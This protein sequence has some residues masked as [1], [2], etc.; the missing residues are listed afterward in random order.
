M[1]EIV[2]LFGAGINR[3]MRWEKYGCSPPLAKDFFQQL[4]K[5]ELFNREFFLNDNSELFEYIKKFWKISPDD[6]KKY[7]FDI[8]E[9]FTL[10]QLQKSAEEKYHN[11]E[12]KKLIKIQNQFTKSFFKFIQGFSSRFNDSFRRFGEQLYREKPTV[13]TFN[14]DTFIEQTIKNASGFC[15]RFQRFPHVGPVEDVEIRHHR[16]NWLPSLAYGVEFDEVELDRAGCPRIV[17]G[18]RF[19]S[20]KENNLYASKIL[21]LHGSINW[22]RYTGVKVNPYIENFKSKKGRVLCSSLYGSHDVLS[23]S[24]D[25]E[26]VES[27]LIMPTLYKD[28]ENEPI[29]SEIW[30]SAKSA[31]SSCEKLII[32]GYSFP[33]TDFYTKKLFLEAFENS[34]P[35]EIII[36]NPDTSV[37]ATAKK[38]TNF[39]GPVMVC[40]NL[41]EFMENYEN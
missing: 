35:K 19:Y 18:G 31:L 36:I 40:K 30:S 13:L 29:L 34:T 12:R 15:D 11:N 5:H 33:P 39:K 38:L 10:I 23:S 2:Y 26:I 14:Y 9:F 3:G 4:F 8:E 17:E 41:D 1:S 25:G 27:I 28:I 16:S 37:V 24:I 20:F 22:F 7:D 6:L 21:K 32:G